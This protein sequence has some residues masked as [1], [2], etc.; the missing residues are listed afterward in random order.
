MS[1]QMSASDLE[2][3]VHFHADLGK[4]EPDD[5]QVYEQTEE[6]ML[7]DQTQVLEEEVEDSLMQGVVINENENEVV[8]KKNKVLQFYNI[9]AQNPGTFPILN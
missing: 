8:S 4:L 3:L 9:S 7:V 1:D 2:S 6:E 5:D